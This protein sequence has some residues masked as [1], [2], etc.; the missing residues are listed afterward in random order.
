L[1]PLLHARALPGGQVLPEA[2]DRLESELLALL[3]R[4]LAD[5]PLHGFYLDIHGAMAVDGRQDAELRLA[6]A[7]R[8]RVGP[9]CLLSASMD[10]HG[11]VSREFAE[12]VELITAYRTA[13]HVDYEETR[14]RA[15]HNLVSCLVDGV[16]PVRAF[17]RVPVL[18]PGEKTSTRVEPARSIYAALP[19]VEAKDG[20]LDASLLVGYAWADEPR[21]G[22]TVVVYGTD[23][24]A[25][26]REAERLARA[27][28]DA[29]EEFDFCAPAGSADWAIDQA[30]SSSK[31][32]FFISDSGDNPTGGGS[33][34][35]AAFLQ[36]LL[37]R[38]EFRDG[39]RSAIWAAC[40][41]P[42]AVAA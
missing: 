29:R 33:G 24:E 38:R 30:L 23:R 28:W 39:G 16:R 6:R 21:S 25:V 37:A 27:W 8:A 4:A 31:R 7:I 5:G 36:A 1:V 42:D 15:L 11:Q 2:Y 22:A 34:D 14:E 19:E 13:P 32:P 40:V 20:V 9:D 3:E 18:L 17:V 12:T 10:L 41:A 35:T 26:G